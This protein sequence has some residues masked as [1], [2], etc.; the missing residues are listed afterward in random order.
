M[1]KTMLFNSLS[2]RDLDNA[3]IFF[4]HIPKTGGTSLFELFADAYGPEKCFRHS[5]RDGKTGKHSPPIASL[6]DEQ[7]VGYR[8]IGGHIPFS[9][10]GRLKALG[11]KVYHVTVLRD[12]VERIVSDYHFNRERGA[13]DLKA[14]ALEMSLDDYVKFKLADQNS[15][16]VH[17]GQCWFISDS[18][19]FQQSA[20]NIDEHFLF[21]CTIDQLDQMQFA[22]A[23]FTGRPIA[24]P[25][26]RN[27]AKRSADEELSPATRAALRAAS[28][29][30]LRLMEHVEQQFS[31]AVV[32]S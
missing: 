32:Y 7:L 30:D 31:K 6:S 14:K 2:P 13:A 4:N 3:H 10:A 26:H 19:E 28:V 1:K 25:K 18:R 24:A 5:N 21:A 29:A 22:L 9:A 12:P 16:L 11:R 8:F 17:N 23:D 20:R 27:R 15:R